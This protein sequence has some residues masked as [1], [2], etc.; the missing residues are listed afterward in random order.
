MIYGLIGAVSNWLV[1][2]GG[3]EPLV[4]R[5]NIPGLRWVHAA[6]YGVTFA[7][8]T[9]IWWHGFPAFALMA[10]GQSFKWG[11]LIKR[12]MDG[13]FLGILQLSARGGLWGLFLAAGGILAQNWLY[14]SLCILTG[15]TM[16]VVYWMMW[17]IF[18]QEKGNAAFNHWTCSEMLYGFLTWLPLT[19]L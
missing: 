13:K 10:A 9:G 4:N 8:A 1:R 7:V 2:G 3:I 19:I 11:T 17:R 15:L 18:R 5:D 12:I 6:I 16:G 14:A